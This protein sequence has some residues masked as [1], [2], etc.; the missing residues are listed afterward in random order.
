M[1]FSKYHGL[2]NDFII[3]DRPEIDGMPIS[4]ICNRRTGIGADGILLITPNQNESFDMK[5]YNADGS[6]PEMCG[7]GL[8]CA[9]AYLRDT[10]QSPSDHFI[11]GTGAGPIRVGY[12]GNLVIAE[13]G[14]VQDLGR[15]RV[16]LAERQFEG[17]YISTGNPHF[18]LFE[19]FSSDDRALYGARLCNHHTFPKGANISFAD[20]KSRQEVELVVWERGCGFTEACGTGACATTVAGWLQGHLDPGEVSVYLPG[21]TLRI[22]G[23]AENVIMT[24]PAVH[25]FDGVL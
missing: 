2:G 21:G 13:L 1:R 14:T 9:A 17:Q 15:H 25:V 18:I 23:T 3:V 10:E 11:F 20:L 4:D 16:E 19:R 7:N 6:V 24:G 5:V 12:S 8:R 22:S